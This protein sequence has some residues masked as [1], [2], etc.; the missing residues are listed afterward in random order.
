VSP[1]IR[2]L[3]SQCGFADENGAE[4]PLAVEEPVQE[5][6]SATAVVKEQSVPITT[7]A[8]TSQTTSALDKVSKQLLESTERSSLDKKSKSDKKAKKAKKE[9]KAKLSASDDKKKQDDTQSAVKEITEVKSTTEIKGVAVAQVVSKPIEKTQVPV[10]NS[11][12]SSAPS[13]QPSV[14]DLRANLKLPFM[15]PGQPPVIKKQDEEVKRDEDKRLSHLTI[16]RVDSNPLIKRRP[17]SRNSTATS[18][19]TDGLQEVVPSL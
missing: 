7:P 8:S 6:A 5:A 10:S 12:I 16:N 1:S 9:K 14:A 2:K 17:P 4:A 13:P 15:N 11:Q 18:L 3:Q 19:R